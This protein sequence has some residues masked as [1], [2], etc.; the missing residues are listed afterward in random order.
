MR[1]LVLVVAAL[2]GTAIKSQVNDQTWLD[3][4]SAY[5]SRINA[6]YA[7]A[8]HSPL[9]PVDLER[10][11]EL[12]RFAPDARFKV[13]AAFKPKKGKP[14]GMKTTTDRLPQYEAVGLLRFIMDGKKERLT[15]FRNIDLSKKPGYANYLFVP[16]TDL[17]NGE[18]TYGGG[19]YIDLRG[20]LGK[21]V[22]LDFNKAYNPYC[23]YGGKYSCPIPPIENHLDLRIEAGVKA[24]A[25]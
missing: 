7:D 4:L 6:D 24:F 13:T 21:A 25:H 20:P 5:W 8:E 1:A 3:S 19:R 11:T 15:V 22:E 17:T 23:A 9:L 14:F 16:F 2:S 12:E 18:E 10:F